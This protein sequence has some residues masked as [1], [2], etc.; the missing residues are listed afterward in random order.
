MIN[1]NIIFIIINPL[2]KLSL[3]HYPFSFLLNF[4]F[5]IPLREK[6]KRKSC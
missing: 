1:I 2:K 4:L 6:D 5:L 3:L